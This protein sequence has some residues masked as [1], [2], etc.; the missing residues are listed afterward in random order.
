[1]KRFRI[2]A[3]VVLLVACEAITE[4][5][6]ACSPPGGGEAVITGI[7]TDPA[8]NPVV[9]ATV[10][11]RVMENET[12]QEPAATITRTATSAAAGR[13]RHIESWSGGR[14]C[15]RLWAE[16]PQGSTLS[17]SESQLVQINYGMTVVPDSVDVTLRLR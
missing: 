13:F 5:I 12:C 8:T 16:P 9:G 6:C 3:A 17:A 10:L 15:F 1:M 11:V 14:K 2:A 7:V 4:P